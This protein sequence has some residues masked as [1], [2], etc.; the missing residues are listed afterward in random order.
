MALDSPAA[1]ILTGGK[2]T[3]M[4]SDKASLLLGGKTLLQRARDKARTVCAS[5]ST[6]GSQAQFGPDAKSAMPTINEFGASQ[7][8][9]KKI[10]AI[11][12]DVRKA[13]VGKKK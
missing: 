13:I 7:K 9:N 5:V 10:Q 2:S 3:R 4:G 11:L 8:D 6:V 12:K 1:F